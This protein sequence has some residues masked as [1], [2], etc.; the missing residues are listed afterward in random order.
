M[1]DLIMTM[2]E[3]ELR[4]VL[5]GLAHDAPDATADHITRTLAVT[6]KEA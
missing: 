6:R 5:L 2:N 1:T 3:V 4:A